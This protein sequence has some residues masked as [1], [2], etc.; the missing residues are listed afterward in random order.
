MP[1]TLG[2]KFQEKY[3]EIVREQHN[4]NQIAVALAWLKANAGF[5]WTKAG[6]RGGGRTKYNLQMKL[7]TKSKDLPAEAAN[8]AYATDGI[9]QLN[10]LS[11]MEFETFTI[12]TQPAKSIGIKV[13][14]TQ[15]LNDM[16]ADG[17]KMGVELKENHSNA[18]ITVMETIL[19]KMVDID[20]TT[21]NSAQV[22][23]YDKTKQKVSEF[24]TNGINQLMLFSDNRAHGTS[25]EKIITWVNPLVTTVLSYELGTQFKMVDN[26]IMQGLG[27]GFKHLN[28]NFLEIDTLNG[29]AGTTARHGAAANG[30]RLAG[31]SMTADA[32]A[33]L[34]DIR[35]DVIDQKLGTAY[36]WGRVYDHCSELIQQKR[37]VL[38]F[39]DIADLNTDI[40]VSAK[41]NA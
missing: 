33:I 21:A 36:F 8:A 13:Q 37:I 10:N 29:F 23:V 31:I 14:T 20:Y 16:L 30:K 1:A 12:E 15:E 35:E 2:K 7:R 34:M 40:A 6:K 38:Y 17:F 5:E 22:K 41:V 32:Y 25:K 9:A 11:T 3:D 19:S 24:L 4:T 39:A 18:M 26:F 27:T 28:N